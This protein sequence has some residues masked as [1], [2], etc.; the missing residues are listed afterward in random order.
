MSESP[1]A[2][3]EILGEPIGEGGSA[4]V[5][6]A[7]DVARGLEVVLK[8]MK[9]D[10]TNQ[11]QV[12]RFQVEAEAAH[13]LEGIPDVAQVL[14]SGV[15]A[16]GLFAGRPFLALA[17]YPGTLADC[18]AE[19]RGRP[20]AIAT[21]V[22]R[23]TR[24]VQLAH[25]QNV[26][27]L[28]IKPSNILLDSID[29][30]GSPFVADF[31]LARW[32]GDAK[33]TRS[34]VIRGTPAN[35]APEQ[36]L[37][38]ALSE[39]TDIYGIGTVLYELIVERAPYEGTDDDV[40]RKLLS[41]DPV[42]S[43]SSR[44]I[45]VARDLEQI[46]LCCLEKRVS[47]R[48]HSAAD[49]ADDLEA[50]LERKPPKIARLRWPSRLRRL[51]LRYPL[52]AVFASVAGAVTVAAG[53][54][55]LWTARELEVALRRQVLQSNMYA[56]EAKAGEV[57]YLLRGFADHLRACAVDPVVIAHLA[58]PDPK[59]VPD[60]P[61]AHALE[62]C[63]PSSTFDSLLL[64][65]PLGNPVLRAPYVSTEYLSR[66]FSFR[67]YF[68]GAQRLAERRLSGHGGGASPG[69]PELE[70]VYV[71]RAHTSEG[72]GQFKFSLSI[73]V[74]DGSSSRSGPKCLGYLMATLGTDSTIASLS[75]SDPND[76]QRIGMLVALRDRERWEIG[77]P[78]PREFRVLIHQGLSHGDSVSIR[79]PELER[80]LG[81]IDAEDP[82]YQHQFRLP[83]A[84]SALYSDSLFDP[85]SK[86]RDRWL[87][88]FARVG[89]T[90][91]VVIVETRYAAVDSMEQFLWR[92]VLCA[93]ALL[94]LGFAVLLIWIGA[95]RRRA[96]L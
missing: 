61:L 34:G 10:T 7:Y 86:V 52:I 2:N 5:Y 49:L 87:A 13:L 35:M 12:A 24:A 57:L 73:P 4:L 18:I 9:G 22:L 16:S 51:C 54:V 74:F 79:A 41:H 59:T 72:D 58:R 26:L 60:A 14:N 53:A 20:A 11:E 66:N 55:G 88:G 56:A 8:V 48:Y 38:R 40:L 25:A 69:Q 3:Y 27:H 62:T 91:Q 43:P 44:G 42:P 83:Q 6:P 64:L 37:G 32:G 29:G 45:S 84:G 19:Y 21:L 23:I 96:W 30:D 71:A 63:A 67:D 46:C 89:E 70:A 95:L 39:A 31:G 78:L 1:S 17:R 28:D 36:A 47:I 92:I 77:R 80:F 15:L 85:I 81:V 68:S 50:F 33:H 82:R 94:A 90:S 76:D 75:F 93:G 65:D